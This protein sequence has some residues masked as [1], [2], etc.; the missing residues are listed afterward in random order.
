MRKGPLCSCWLLSVIYPS[1][2]CSKDQ[3]IQ[4]PEACSKKASHLQH[5]RL[6]AHQ[7]NKPSTSAN[8]RSPCRACAWL[9]GSVQQRCPL[10]WWAKPIYS[11]GLLPPDP[12]PVCSHSMVFH[13]V[14]S[15][16]PDLIARSSNP[17]APSCPRSTFMQHYQVPSAEYSS[18]QTCHQPG[19]GWGLHSTTAWQSLPRQPPF[20]QSGHKSSLQTPV[21]SGG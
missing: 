17:S 2:Y 1:C 7:L 8:C 10:C 11:F 5:A 13:V 15:Q 6:Q 9:L 12:C 16:T 21:W 4:L 20:P 3:S 19:P 18:Y 14:N